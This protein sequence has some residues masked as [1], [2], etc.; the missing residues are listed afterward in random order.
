MITEGT[1]DPR[2]N[3]PDRNYPNYPQ[4]QNERR[5]YPTYPGRRGNTATTQTIIYDVKFNRSN[6]EQ[7]FITSQ[8]NVI[9]YRG[10]RFYSVAKIVIT[11]R[12]YFPYVIYDYQTLLDVDRK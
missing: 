12:C 10:N 7:Y 1:N 9:R 6:G 11:N 2:G 4:T 8:N 5:N 3:Y